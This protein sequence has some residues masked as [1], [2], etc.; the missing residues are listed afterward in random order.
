MVPFSHARG[1]PFGSIYRFSVSFDRI[2]YAF[3]RYLDPILM[4]FGIQME[5][6]NGLGTKTGDGKLRRACWALSRHIV[7]GHVLIISWL[8]LPYVAV[9]LDNSHDPG[10]HCS[11]IE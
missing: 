9:G 1:L 3:L 4:S 2:R 5:L 6:K 11:I 7:H 10:W 8:W